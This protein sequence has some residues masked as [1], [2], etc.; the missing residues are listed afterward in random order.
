MNVDSK[1]ISQILITDYR[2]ALPHVSC[3]LTWGIPLNR[4]VAKAEYMRHFLSHWSDKNLDTK[5]S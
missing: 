3:C 2:I 4:I 5:K 1:P